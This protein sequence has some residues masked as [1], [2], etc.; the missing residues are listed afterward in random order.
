MG[1]GYYCMLE[2]PIQGVDPLAID[3]KA[4]ARAHFHSQSLPDHTNSPLASI[5]E[6]FSLN[7]EDALGFAE[8]EG[9]DLGDLSL[10]PVKWND[11]NAGLKMVSGLL[12]KFR[13]KN[14]SVV[15]PDSPPDARGQ[16]IADL[17]G[18]EA[19]LRAAV[20]RRVRFYLTCDM[21]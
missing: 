14:F 10:P 17:E 2:Q 16:V 11:A 13:D 3:G 20:E 8:G 1:M 4:L 15:L 21:P 7:P 18:I 6:F 5:D 19:I 12:T 9:V